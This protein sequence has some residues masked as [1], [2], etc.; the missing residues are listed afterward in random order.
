MDLNQLGVLTV[1]TLVPKEAA[2]TL[3]FITLLAI[4]RWSGSHRFWLAPQG[5]HIRAYRMQHVVNKALTH[6]GNHRHDTAGHNQGWGRASKA[7]DVQ[8]FGR[9]NQIKA[10][11]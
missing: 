10:G 11:R 3:S 1:D 4:P 8:V 9:P 2:N 6:A 7:A 5:H